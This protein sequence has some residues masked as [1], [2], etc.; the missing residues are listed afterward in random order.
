MVNNKC[1]II[2]IDKTVK[3]TWEISRVVNN[4]LID[5]VTHH[6]LDVCEAYNIS[7]EGVSV[8][9]C[10]LTSRSLDFLENSVA[11]E[12]VN[13]ESFSHTLK[14]FIE[15]GLLTG[16]RGHVDVTGNISINYSLIFISA[17]SVI[18]T[19]EIFKDEGLH[20]SRTH[21]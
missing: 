20:T 10:P 5:I 13:I 15:E 3:Q 9:Y 2:N 7:T 1:L 18:I 17:G 16:R 6:C 12:Y 11:V 14:S 19:Q 8:N 4:F 21:E